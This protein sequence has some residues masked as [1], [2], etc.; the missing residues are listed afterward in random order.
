LNPKTK[1]ILRSK[2]VVFNETVMFSDSQT[3]ADSDASDA[4]DV[5]D[6][7]QQRASMQVEHVEEKENDTAKNGD[8]DHEPQ[9]DDNDNHFVPPS[10]PIFAATKSFYRN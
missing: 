2:N 1:R 8:V 6:D 10:P 7:E 9:F 4:S 5:S 3:S